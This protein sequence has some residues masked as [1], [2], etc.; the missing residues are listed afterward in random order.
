M[1]RERTGPGR[2]ELESP[3]GPGHRKQRRAEPTY[4]LFVAVDPAESAVEHLADAIGTLHVS[5][6]HARIA[7]RPLWHVTVAFLGDVPASRVADAQTALTCAAGRA[8]PA[9]LRIAGGG[10]F[11]RGGRTIL[12]AGVDGDVEE[13]RGLAQAVRRELKRARLPYDDK[14]YRPHLTVARPGERLAAELVEADVLALRGY[15]G[16]DWPMESVHLV[17]SY[18]GPHPRHERIG[19]YPLGPKGDPLSDG[20]SNG[21]GDG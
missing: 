8:Q 14:P 12:W 9:R 5:S 15:Q 20:D 17:R 7:A 21:N 11:G 13:L 18:L 4:R 6:A 2:S 10:R 16:P 3:P 1:T 19:S